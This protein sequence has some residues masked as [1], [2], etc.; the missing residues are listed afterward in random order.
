[1]LRMDQR[2][3]NTDYRYINAGGGGGLYYHNDPNLPTVSNLSTGINTV[4][5]HG[6]VIVT[7]L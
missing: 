5:E 2:S 3:S 6:K 7:K 1:M 4:L